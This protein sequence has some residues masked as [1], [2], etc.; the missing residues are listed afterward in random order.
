MT[1]KDKDSVFFYERKFYVFSNFSSFEITWN[2]RIWK[3]S[4]YAYQAAKFEDEKIINE[5]RNAK[6]SHDAMKL[7]KVIYSDKKRKDWY[8]VKLQIMEDIVRTKLS[9]HFY[10]QKKLSETGN[11][12]IIENSPRDSFW[13]WWP[14]KDGQNH[15]GKIWMKVR[16]ELKEGKIPPLEE[17]YK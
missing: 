7:A 13:G 9:Q 4:E 10:I 15:L 8:D 2:G 11:R 6:S 14:N 16:K 1:N 17:D 12:E 3:T 5:I